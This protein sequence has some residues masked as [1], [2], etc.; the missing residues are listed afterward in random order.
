MTAWNSSGAIARRAHPAGSRL[1][2][3]ALPIESLPVIAEALAVTV[4]SASVPVKAGM[5]RR[6]VRLLNTPLYDAWLIAWG[7]T[8]LLDLHDHGGSAGAV[9]VAK[10]EL[11]ETYTD[12][13][14]RHPLRSRVVPA[15][16][17]VAITPTCVHE[18]WNPGPDEALS[19]HV[20]SPPLS[21][22]TF[23]DHRPEQFL[24]PLQTRRGD[25]AAVE[26]VPAT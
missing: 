5:T 20:Y 15:E 19:V 7:S 22:M 17:S 26:D 11:V 12:L 8:A 23:Y 16:T 4:A 13:K 2:Q 9:H 18:V 14:R 10:G 21:A 25:L 1:G 3:A 24:A 6:Y